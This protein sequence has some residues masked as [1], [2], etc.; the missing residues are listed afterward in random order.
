MTG[1]PI[2]MK[3]ALKLAKD[4]REKAV[5]ARRVYAVEDVDKPYEDPWPIEMDKE[6]VAGQGN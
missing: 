2:T 3:E 5:Q 6:S 4:V 1:R